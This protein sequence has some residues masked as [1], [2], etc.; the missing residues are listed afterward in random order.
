M[1]FFTA[2]SKFGPAAR[3]FELN[4]WFDSGSAA[5]RR[6][7]LQPPI[8]ALQ[9]AAAEPDAAG[10]YLN[11]GLRELKRGR[12]ERPTQVRR[13][14]T[15]SQSLRGVRPLPNRSLQVTRDNSTGTRF[16]YPDART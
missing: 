15:S 14:V 16:V 6:G 5:A 8:Q 1:E 11:A 10:G 4:Y 7:D 9:R 3:P 13:C 12:A 2:N